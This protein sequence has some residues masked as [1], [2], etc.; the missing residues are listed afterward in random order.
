[1]GIGWGVD[2]ILIFEQ[3]TRDPMQWVPELFVSTFENNKTWRFIW[4]WWS[5]SCYGSPGLKD[6][7]ERIA[8]KAVSWDYGNG[9][10]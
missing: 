6:F 9:S 4:G 7:M 1:M 3:D 10:R 2:M 8:D 5:L